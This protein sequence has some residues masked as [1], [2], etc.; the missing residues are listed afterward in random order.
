MKTGKTE[1]IIHQTTGLFF[2]AVLVGLFACNQHQIKNTNQ[3]TMG[4]TTHNEELVKQAE[5]DLLEGVSKAI[6]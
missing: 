4:E 2:I 1:G 5:S 6:C 3:N